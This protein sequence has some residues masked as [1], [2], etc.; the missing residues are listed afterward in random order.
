MK[1]KEGRICF[2]SWCE[3][4]RPSR[5]ARRGWAW[6]QLPHQ[7]QEADAGTESAAGRRLEMND[8]LGLTLFFLFIPRTPTM[9]WCHMAAFRVGS[10]FIGHLWKHPSDT[11]RRVS[12][13][14]F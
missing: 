10:L 3:G 7:K 12:P 13:R 11:G 1:L 8:G 4:H 5:W 14:G 6:L 9:G 2:G